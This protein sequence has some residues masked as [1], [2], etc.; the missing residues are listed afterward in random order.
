MGEGLMYEAKATQKPTPRPEKEAPDVIY[1]PV[2]KDPKA[3]CSNDARWF[4]TTKLLKVSVPSHK[5]V[6]YIRADLAVPVSRL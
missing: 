6:K 5:A 2:E 1:I 3:G 4:P